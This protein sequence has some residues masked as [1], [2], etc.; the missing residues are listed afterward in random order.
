MSKELTAIDI[1]KLANIT[2]TY[3]RLLKKAGEIPPA[4]DTKR[5]PHVWYSDNPKLIEFLNSRKP[6]PE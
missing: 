1:A 6:K 3:F 4:D 5:A 2:I